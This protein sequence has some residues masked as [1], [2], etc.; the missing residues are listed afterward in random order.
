MRAGEQRV[1]VR[2]CRCDPAA[3]D[4]AAGAADILDDERLP[5][6]ARPSV[7]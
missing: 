3:A 5:E 1:A 4:G 2:R 6:R 7:R